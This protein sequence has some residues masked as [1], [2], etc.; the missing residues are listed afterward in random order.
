MRVTGRIGNSTISFLNSKTKEGI[1]GVGVSFS[2]FLTCRIMTWTHVSPLDQEWSSILSSLHVLLTPLSLFYLCFH[3]W[4]SPPNIVKWREHTSFLSLP[5]FI[6]II[7]I[8]GNTPYHHTS[9]SFHFFLPNSTNQKPTSTATHTTLLS[10][11]SL[12]ILYLFFFFLFFCLGFPNSKNLTA[13]GYPD[14]AFPHS[15]LNNLVCLLL[16]LLFLLL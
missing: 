5:F 12:L 16:A 15:H 11:A 2:R 13:K 6:A 14:A 4:I 3:A 8:K 7:T 10:F 9:S 1:V